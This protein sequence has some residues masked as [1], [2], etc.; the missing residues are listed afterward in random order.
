[1]RGLLA[2]RS[3]KSCESLAQAV[4]SGSEQRLQVLLS[5]KVVLSM[6]LVH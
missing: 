4:P 1:M 6:R 3:Y 2:E 5:N